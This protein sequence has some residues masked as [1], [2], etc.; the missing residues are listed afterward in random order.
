M[1]IPTIV[2]S[3]GAWTRPSAFST[4]TAKLLEKG[5]PCETPPH[6]SVG[7]EPPTKTLQDDVSSLRSVLTRLIETEGKDVIVVAH[8][9][10]GVVASCA[11]EG[12]S[13]A[14]RST[15]GICKPGGVCRVAYLAA[16]A[17]DKGMS[18]VDMLGGEFLPWMQ[19]DVRPFFLALI[20]LVKE[21]NS[22]G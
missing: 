8:S 11:V 17:L 15:A 1:T 21:A 16:F 6:P 19:A 2:F 22:T 7:S 4:V 5:I 12:L 20:I 10:G 13:K 9:Y 14:E 3:L 18:L